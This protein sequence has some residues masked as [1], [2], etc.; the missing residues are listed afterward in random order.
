MLQKKKMLSFLPKTIFRLIL[1]ILLLIVVFIPN[2]VLADDLKL[3][4]NLK[5]IVG[6]FSENY[7][8]ASSQGIDEKES[9]KVAARKI[10]S[11][12]IFSD[13][14]KEVNAL[15]KNDLV[16]YISKEI[17]SRCGDVLK[18]TKIDLNEY[19]LMLAESDSDESSQRP[20]K[21]FGMG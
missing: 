16:L 20:F 2:I 17:F 1:A 12:L 21:P 11:K 5:G 13:S 3:S 14:F 19:L 4:I 9:A 10:V 18:I 15:N 8:L 6:D 7:C